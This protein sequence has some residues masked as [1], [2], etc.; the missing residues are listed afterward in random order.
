MQLNQPLLAEFKHEASNTRKMLERVPAESFSW[1]PHEKSMSLLRLAEHVSELPDWLT[2]TVKQDELNLAEMKRS[3]DNFATTGDLLSA[4]DEKLA[5]GVQALE[6][7]SNENLM[8]NWK[9]RM[10]EHV[11]FD[12]PRIQV[13]RSMVFNHIIHHRGQLSVYLR[14][15]GVPVPGMYGPSADDTF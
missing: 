6:S 8:Q 10:G 15:L 13:V 7:A 14:L 9:L 3:T 2:F 4:F 12:M 5:R 1:K 11:I